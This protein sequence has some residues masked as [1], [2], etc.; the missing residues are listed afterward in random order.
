M[1]RLIA[2]LETRTR[3]GYAYKIDLRLRPSGRSGPLVTS[4]DGFGEYH[5]QSAAVWERQS[6]VRARVIAGDPWLAEQV[7]AVRQNVIFRGPISAASVAE[8]AAMRARMEHEIGVENHDRLNV[9]QGRGGLVDIE[10]ITQMVVLRHGYEFPKLRERNTVALLD[11]MRTCGLLSDEDAATLDDDYRFLSRLE[12]RLRIESDQAAWA[13][14]T[15]YEQLTPI[16]KRM[17]YGGVNAAAELLYEVERRRSRIRAVFD[18]CFAREQEGS[19]SGT[20][21]ALD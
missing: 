5:R 3:E 12:N 6:M 4:L 16:A 7:E 18:A 19:S 17:G 20:G 1:Q 9:K 10:F 13:L 21:S 8:I 15:S 11:G 14:P 2:I